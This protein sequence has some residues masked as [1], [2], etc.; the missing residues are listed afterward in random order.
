VSLCKHGFEGSRVENIIFEGMEGRTFPITH[1]YKSTAKSDK[2]IRINNGS[3]SYFHLRVPY[4]ADLA[5]QDLSHQNLPI[6]TC[7]L[8]M[9]E[10]HLALKMYQE[11]G[12][13]GEKNPSPKVGTF[14]QRSP[15]N[16]L[17]TSHVPFGEGP[18]GL[19]DPEL[20]YLQFQST[21]AFM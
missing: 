18:T 8:L 13:I 20:R 7:H 1:W 19:Q 10:W 15:T 2:Q 6:D 12:V 9:A 11:R 17:F 3:L 4:S 14:W 21:R 5:D 16:E